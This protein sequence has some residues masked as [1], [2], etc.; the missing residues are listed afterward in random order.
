MK[1]RVWRLALVMPCS[2]ALP[3]AGL[4]PSASAFVFSRSN[5]G[6]SNL[7]A[8]QKRRLAAVLDLDLLQHL[9]DDHFDVLV[10]DLDALQR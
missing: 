1:E 6:R 2:T 8:D 3:R 7:I 9:A 5:S 4:R 10:V